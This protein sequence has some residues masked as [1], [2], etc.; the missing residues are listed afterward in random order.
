MYH[1]PLNMGFNMAVCVVCLFGRS[2]LA[3]SLRPS[4]L[5]SHSSGKEARPSHQHVKAGIFRGS[6]GAY[7]FSRCGNTNAGSIVPFLVWERV[8]FTLASELVSLL[9]CI[10]TVLYQVVCFAFRK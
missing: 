9:V 2:R 3:A 6:Q 8:R 4:G 7:C 5:S 1:V 10:I